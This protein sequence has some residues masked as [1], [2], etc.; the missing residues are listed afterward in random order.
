MTELIGKVVEVV[1]GE[2]VYIG[3]LVEVNEE[4]VYLETE[5]GWVVVPVEKVA[6]IREK[7]D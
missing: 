5:A 4:E 3:K 7:E 6:L 2:T 1:T